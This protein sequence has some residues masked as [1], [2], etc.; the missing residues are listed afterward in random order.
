V[1]DVWLWWSS[2]K[3]SAWALHELRQSG[4]YRVTRL[5]TTLNGDADRVAMH[6]VRRTLLERQARAVGVPLEAV[7]LPHPC[8]NREYEAAVADAQPDLR[9]RS[10]EPGVRS[11]HGRQIA[12]QDVGALPPSR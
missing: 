12:R 2:G 1:R 8:S 10:G 6:A 4:E 9:C 3:D 11:R 7:A 5:V